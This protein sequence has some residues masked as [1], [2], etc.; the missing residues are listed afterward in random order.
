[1]NA[2]TK[3]TQ[4]T[5]EFDQLKIRLKTTWMTGDYDFFPHYLEKEGE[6]FFRQLGA[7]LGIR[8]LDVG[9]GAAP[10]P[11]LRG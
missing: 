6:R 8:L 11:I 5:K 9:C 1:V 2:I 4:A 7:S 3:G 10:D